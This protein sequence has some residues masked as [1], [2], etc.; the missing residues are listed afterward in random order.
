FDSGVDRSYVGGVERG[1]ENPSVDVLDKLA[2]ALGVPL[3]SLFGEIDGGAISG[4]KRGRK[5]ASG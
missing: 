2:T 1:T 4:L 3:A 5:P